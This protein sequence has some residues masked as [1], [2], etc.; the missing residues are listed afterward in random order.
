MAHSQGTQASVAA[1]PPVAFSVSTAYRN[2]VIALI[3]LVMLLRF[4]D[5]QI[6]SVLL[7]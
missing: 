3:W 4:V 7:E 2:Y 6:I 1:A 5:L